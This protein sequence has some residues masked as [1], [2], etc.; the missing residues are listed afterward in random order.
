MN[1]TSGL[2]I[3]LMFLNLV[4]LALNIGLGSVPISISDILGSL[5]G[6]EK[7]D[8]G[9]QFRLDLVLQYRMLAEVR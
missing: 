6:S 4:A 9:F 3:A 7:V 1:R 5:S 8:L 2:L